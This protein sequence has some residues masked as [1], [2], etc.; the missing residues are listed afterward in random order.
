MARGWTRAERGESRTRALCGPGPKS[1][2]TSM[3]VL[4]ITATLPQ[5][6]SPS[7]IGAS[8]ATLIKIV[9]WVFRRARRKVDHAH[10]MV[11]LFR[12]RP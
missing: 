8:I 9:G 6:K 3:V 4:H 5:P 12:P 2:S 1:P 10:L 11:L 7:R